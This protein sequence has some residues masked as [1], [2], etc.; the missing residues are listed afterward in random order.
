ML[1]HRRRG[2]ALRRHSGALLHK[3]PRLGPNGECVKTGPAHQAQ[4]HAPPQ[5]LHR[6]NK[7]AQEPRRQGQP[8]C[9]QAAMA[10]EY[11]LSEYEKTSKESSMIYQL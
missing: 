5:D 7:L 2:C 9:P 1:L 11:H 4:P 10:R 8:Q 6:A 3:N